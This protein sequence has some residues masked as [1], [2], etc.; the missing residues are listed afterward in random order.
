MKFIGKWGI[1]EKVILTHVK[2]VRLLRTIV[3]GVK[4]RAKGERDW[5]QL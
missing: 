4:S 5:F 3:T 1:K 2:T